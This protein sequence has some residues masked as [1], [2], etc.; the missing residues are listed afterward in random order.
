M[1]G[2]LNGSGAVKDDLLHLPGRGFDVTRS[3]IPIVAAF[4]LSLAI[5]GGAFQIGKLFSRYEIERGEILERL[6][7]IEGKIDRILPGSASKRLRHRSEA[8]KG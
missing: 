5:A 3:T 1:S 8:D 4:A 2:H 6:D 7:T